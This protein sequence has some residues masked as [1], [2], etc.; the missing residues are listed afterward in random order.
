MQ[1]AQRYEDE[2]YD[3][4]GRVREGEVHDIYDEEETA[5]L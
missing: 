4:R 3:I 5:M 2:V 1:A